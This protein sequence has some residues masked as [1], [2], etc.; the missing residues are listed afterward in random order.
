[1]EANQSQMRADMKAGQEK[2]EA[3][4]R[5]TQ[6]EFIEDIIKRDEGILVSTDKWTQGL[7]E[8]Q[9]SEIHGA[10]LDIQVMRKLIRSHKGSLEHD[11]QRSKPEWGLDI[12]SI[13]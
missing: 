7:C 6:T 12:L 3:M 9:D 11:W 10:R 8:E 5:T 4:M 1:M 13:Q 2:M